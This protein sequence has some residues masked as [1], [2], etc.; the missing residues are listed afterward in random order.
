MRNKSSLLIIIYKSTNFNYLIK[1][2]E[3]DC[4]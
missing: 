2:E 4:Y 3:Q 1:F